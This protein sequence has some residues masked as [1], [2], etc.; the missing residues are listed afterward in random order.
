VTRDSWFYR[1]DADSLG[2]IM[3]LLAVAELD[4]REWHRV[5]EALLEAWPT[6]Q[7]ISDGVQEVGTLH[8]GPQE[9]DV[10]VPEV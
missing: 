6:R 1:K 8:E 3:G 4:I 7:D 9:A 2:R 10:D 5:R